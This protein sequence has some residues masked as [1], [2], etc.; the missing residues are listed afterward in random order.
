MAQRISRAKRI[1]QSGRCRSSR[2]RGHGDAGP[3]PRVQRGLFRRRR[4]GGRGHPADPA[5]DCSGGRPRGPRSAR[6]DASPPCPPPQPHPTRRKH[7]GARRSGP[8]PVG[9]RR[10]SPKESTSHKPRSGAISSANTRP[11]RR[12]PP[13]TPTRRVSRR[14]TG[15]RSWS[16]TTSYSGSPTLRSSG[17]TVPSQSARPT[18][19]PQDW[20]HWPSVDEHVPRRDA[21][22]AYLHEKNGDLELAARLY[23][24]AARNAPNLAERDHQTRQAARLNQHLQRHD[25]PAP[26]RETAHRSTRPPAGGRHEVRQPEATCAQPPHREARPRSHG[27]TAT[28]CSATAAGRRPSGSATVLSPLPGAGAGP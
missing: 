20:R 28:S 10:S 26:T 1:G 4:S 2:R 8:Q 21:V 22:A 23:A 17:S 5:A 3:V 15:S 25:D 19:R 16:G 14:P 12:S 6:P 13:S 24:N 27:Q 18:A 11:K 7:R 9:H